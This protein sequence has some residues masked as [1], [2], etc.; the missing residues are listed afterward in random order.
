MRAGVSKTTVSF[1]F[2][3]PQRISSETYERIM[4]IARDIGYSPDPV[5]RI[6]SNKKTNNIGIVL[7]QTISVLFQN[8]Y[9]GELLRGV[10]SVCDQEGF[11][12]S[13][14]SPFKGLVTQTI[15][16]AAVD[17]ILIMGISKDS[18]VHATFKQ[19]TMPYVTIDAIDTGN[20]VN[21]GI[22]DE[23]L[24]EQL[25]DILL[26][27]NH[28]R[29]C[30]CLLQ[31]ISPDLQKADTSAT[32]EARLHGIYSSAKKHSL[33]DSEL[34]QFDFINTPATLAD[35]Y[36]IALS[37]LKKNDRPTAVFCMAD[38]QAYG[39]YRAARELSISI[40]DDLSIVSFDD[41]P[42]TETLT[43][44]L[45]C[46]HQSAFEKGRTATKLLFKL[47]AGR[48]CET[49]YLDACIEYR[50]SVGPVTR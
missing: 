7:P 31:S 24:A 38:I 18:D 49:V 34:K 11:A 14:L 47:I 20:F 21:V 5:A 28:R 4:T 39:F 41:I 6:L 8:P 33:T 15:L 26:D 10:G 27:N 22:R 9:H 40:P 29:I 1:A 17:G 16:N 13:V 19:R 44:G 45:T 42:I 3:D 46:V 30:F 43:P 37:V 25:M 36:N 2:N 23:E 35:S 32:R 12:V 48:P 50:E